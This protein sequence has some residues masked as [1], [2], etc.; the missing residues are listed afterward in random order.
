MS[1]EAPILSVIAGQS[2]HGFYGLNGFSPIGGEAPLPIRA[3]AVRRRTPNPRYR[4]K[5]IIT[6]PVGRFRY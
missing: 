4:A 1:G 3:P 6:A 5:R 2:V